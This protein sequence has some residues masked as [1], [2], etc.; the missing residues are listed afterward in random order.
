MPIIIISSEY[1]KPL[2][3]I[4]TGFFLPADQAP[5]KQRIFVDNLRRFCYNGFVKE[6]H[7]SGVT[8]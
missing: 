4:I 2:R 3:R 8:A 6:H 7:N 5:H 1:Y